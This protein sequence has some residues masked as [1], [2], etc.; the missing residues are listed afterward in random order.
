MHFAV[1][2][3][4]LF[5][6]DD[7]IEE[8]IAPFQQFV[9]EDIRE[10]REVQ[11]VFDKVVEKYDAAVTRHASLSNRKEVS[12]LREEAFILYDARKQYIRASLDYTQRIIT[13]QQDLN[14]LILDQMM[15]TI[16]SHSDFYETACDVFKGLKP[17]MDAVRAKLE[18]GQAVNSSLSGKLDQARK[19]IEEEV[20]STFNP[21]NNRLPTP[22]PEPASCLPRRPATP[23]QLTVSP[24]F[25]IP[26]PSTP[27]EKEGYLFRRLTP[28]GPLAAPVWVRR[29]FVLRDGG[30]SYCM[31]VPAGRLR[32]KVVTSIAV[33][34]LLIT[35]RV[36]KNEDRR[37]CFEFVGA[38]RRPIMVQAESEEEMSSWIASIEAAKYQTL[39]SSNP[40]TTLALSTSPTPPSL[41]SSTSSSTPTVT[42]P[43]QPT[44]ATPTTDL[45]LADPD[46]IEEDGFTLRPVRG[47][48]RHRRMD[49][50]GSA[51]GEEADGEDSDGEGGGSGGPA[52]SEEEGG[53]ARD[54]I[55]YNDPVMDRRNAELHRLLKSVP[56]SDYLVDVFS[57]ALQKDI[58]VQGRLYATKNR[59]CFYSNILGFV[60]MVSFNVLFQLVI[61]FKDVTA[62]NRKATPFYTSIMIV[63][64][65]ATH[66]F[67]IWRVQ[68]DLRAFT[69]LKAAWKNVLEPDSLTAQELYD[70]IALAHKNQDEKMAEHDA[71]QRAAVEQEGGDEEPSSAGSGGGGADGGGAGDVAK[72]AL[73][74]NI[75]P[76]S[77]EI[78][79]A[80][81]DH[82][83]KKEVDI[84]LNAPAKMVADVLWG[85]EG[86]F[87]EKFHGKRGEKGRQQGEWSDGAEPMREVKIIVP[88]N[89]S[90]VKAKETEL[91]ETDH[92]LKKQEYLLYVVE[93]RTQ[94]PALP[95]GDAFSPI[96]RY[97]I[98]WVS[99]DS[100]RLVIHCGI[101]WFKSPMVKGIIKS[102]AMKALS[103][104]GADMVATLKSEI[105]E[106]RN[107]GVPSAP[108]ATSSLTSDSSSP[109]GAGAD[110]AASTQKASGAPSVGGAKG[111]NMFGFASPLGLAVSIA[112]A[113]SVIG[114]VVM[115]WR[116]FGWGSGPVAY[117]QT[118][119]GV[120]E[121]IEE[122]GAGSKLARNS[123]HTF[124]STHMPANATT[125]S[126]LIAARP[127]YTDSTH[128]SIYTRLATSHG[129]IAD[130]KADLARLA[131]EVDAVER[132]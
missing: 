11:K 115:L 38:R 30:L 124:L 43:Q 71:E 7:L 53:D 10:I 5:L 92:M 22:S 62:I 37:Y 61:H 101:K 64:K 128:G 109:T 80:C 6:V 121:W 55:N 50:A 59:I 29:Y 90:M 45:A 40:S 47:H 98:S 26:S 23:S 60:N 51:S 31:V 94:T 65:E 66:T 36:A 84:V 110:T 106:W 25:L 91:V 88:V 52:S 105:D 56:R 81:A 9:R 102:T 132:E 34:V 41:T 13:F 63:T 107:G 57:V 127:R 8:L 14:T 68:D 129:L 116:G 12:A 93:A 131:H 97:C 118:G 21:A 126:S 89:N 108:A 83:E 67:K 74:E 39:N 95:Y 103:D 87:W 122:F 117:G 1:P 130:L 70:Q 73:P 79:C 69:T 32:G 58:A 19:S 99:K 96:T 120:K 24:S 46:A 42:S 35:V 104:G 76:P 44:P 100:C 2:C 48:H 16:Y 72:Y 125:H 114:N 82:P 77:G 119:G 86:K 78:P 49:S 75:P 20:L 113:V 17:S 33:N 4:L 111:S 54:V 15:G 28:K 18:E 85:G 123:V 112:L 27:T 3:Y